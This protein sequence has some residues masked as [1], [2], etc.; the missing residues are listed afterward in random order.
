MVLSHRTLPVD[1]EDKNW[2]R[3]NKLLNG[4]IWKLTLGLKLIDG[5]GVWNEKM[6]PVFKIKIRRFIRENC[7]YYIDRIL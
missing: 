4:E 6:F 1:T 5:N 7:P 2:L 3:Q